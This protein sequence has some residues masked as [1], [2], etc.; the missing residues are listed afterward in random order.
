M[1]DTIKV[2]GKPMNKTLVYGGVGVVLVAGIYYYRKNKASA[3]SAAS[4][5]AAGS[6]E[7]DPAT[8]YPYGSAEDAAALSSQSDYQSPTVGGGYGYSGYAGG[9]GAGAFGTSAP[10]TFISNADWAQYVEGYEV[11]TMGADAPTVGNVI[12]KYLTGQ[13]LT[14]DNMV[15]IVQSAI[16]IGGYPPVS[17]P[18]GHPPGYVTSTTAP[19]TPPPASTSTPK[20]FQPAGAISNL[21]ATVSGTT[22]TIRWNTVPAP[23]KGYSYAMTELNGVVVKKGT[24]GATAKSIAIGGLHKGWTYNFGIQAL[25]GGAGNNIHITIK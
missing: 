15:S 14:S 7:I 2:A 22:A 21:Q 13:P 9:S 20:G 6:T 16:A 5:T 11:N 3:A 8:G 17:G 23:A 24:L 19:T 18:N 12:G 4:V 10:G 25:P 1:P